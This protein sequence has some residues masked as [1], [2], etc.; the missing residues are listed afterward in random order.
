VFRRWEETMRPYR[1]S[2]VLIRSHR[3][4]HGLNCT[5]KSKNRR[6]SFQSIRIKLRYRVK[7]LLNPARANVAKQ[8]PI[9]VII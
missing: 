3:G 2:L 1:K 4:P 5:I 8:N 9:R 7:T 6:I